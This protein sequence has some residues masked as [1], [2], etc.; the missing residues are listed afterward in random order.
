[1]DD[2]NK[3]KADP[4]VLRRYKKY[5]RLNQRFMLENAQNNPKNNEEPDI[6]KYT[7]NSQLPK[8]ISLKTIKTNND[9]KSHEDDRSIFKKPIK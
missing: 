4:V 8:L 7:K 2:V 6:V 9:N 5:N 1:M 3:S